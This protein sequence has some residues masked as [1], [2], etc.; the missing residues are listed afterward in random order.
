MDHLRSAFFEALA[1]E[2][3]AY[4]ENGR[5]YIRTHHWA[6]EE[7]LQGMLTLEALMGAFEDWVAERG[8]GIDRSS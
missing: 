1:Q 8:G 7:V 5:I 4:V 2:Q 6:P 3:N